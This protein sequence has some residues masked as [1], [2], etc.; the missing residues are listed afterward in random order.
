M[1]QINVPVEDEV[2][3]A[4]KEAARQSGMIFKRWVAMAVSDTAVR[5]LADPRKFMIPHAGIQDGNS[6]PAGAP[7][8]VPVATPVRLAK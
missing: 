2:Y 4:A 5:C 1:K 6:V 8:N 3:T 7:V